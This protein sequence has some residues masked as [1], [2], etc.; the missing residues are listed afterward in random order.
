MVPEEK[1]VPRLEQLY[2][3]MDSG[4]RA[5]AEQAGFS[6]KGCDGSKCC[7]VDLTI[8]TFAERLYLRRG[9]PTLT[10]DH[11]RSIRDRC[12][13]ALEAK[14]ADP[15][16]EQYRSAVCALNFE[17]LCS[18]YQFRP[19][20]CRLAGIPNFFRRPDGRLVEQSGCAR[21][22]G[23]I[24]PAIPELKL[25][26][27]S[28]YETMALIEVDLVKCCKKRAAPRTIA[29]ILVDDHQEFPIMKRTHQQ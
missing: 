21:Y 27:T 2:R 12:R 15:L 28:L 8:H 4:Y 17:G 13:S 1:Y 22:E 7:T 10:P 18:L 3:K 14:A 9:L 6:C 26:R 11:L 20:I 5:A 29:E 25:N 19:M 24:R 16:G 23:E